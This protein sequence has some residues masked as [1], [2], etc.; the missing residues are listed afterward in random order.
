MEDTARADE[1]ERGALDGAGARPVPVRGAVFDCDG[2][3]LDTMGVWYSLE[4]ELAAR[5]GHILTPVEK[6]AL[7]SYTLPETARFFHE[8]L[9]LGA[10]CEEV[11]GIVEELAVGF[12]ATQAHPRPG[13]LAF[14]KRLRAAGVRCAIASSSPHSMLDPGAAATG[15]TPYLDAIVSTDDVGVSKR[16][17]AAYDR[18]RELLGTPKEATWV[19][20]DAA[21]AVRTAKAAGYHVVATW[22]CDESGTFEELAALADVAVRDWH[23][24]DP[25]AFA[26]GV[27]ARP[28]AHPSSPVPTC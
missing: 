6:D 27:Y 25:A 3:L 13:V 23:E 26:R 24:L 17:P 19:F 1:T 14:L 11:V 15:L 28:D 16:E 10:S 21:Y 18:A 12:Y 4:D 5:A 2:T 9:G 22:D 7:R 8:T 20:E